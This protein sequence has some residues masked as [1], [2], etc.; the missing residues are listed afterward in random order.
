MV[1]YEMYWD[2]RKFWLYGSM[3]L[4]LSLFL[5]SWIGAVRL[6]GGDLGGLTSGSTSL[7]GVDLRWLR[8]SWWEDGTF[9]LMSVPPG[10]VAFLIG[11]ASTS[12]T[13]ARE[14]DKGTLAALLAQP[15]RRSEIFLGK[16]LAKVL[17]FL[18]VS[19]AIVL[20]MILL[21]TLV[22]GPQLYLVW[23]PVVILD[24]TLILAFYA[25]FAQFLSCFFRRSRSVFF[26]IVLTWFL[27]F[28]LME[29]AAFQHLTL[30]PY[31]YFVPINSA[32]LALAGTRAY[33][34]NPTG[35]VPVSPVPGSSA[36]GAAPAGTL[37][38]L[39]FNPL[40]FG[41]DSTFQFAVMA[42]AGLVLG[43]VLFL[44]LGWYAFRRI[45]IGG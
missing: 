28:G 5:V 26:I 18:G 17:V 33:F 40:S 19:A 37:P 30:L 12:G 35:I 29:S 22:F 11:E 13:V 43:T 23:A 14:R 15:L 6:L 27:L 41:T 24:L 42:T 1:R 31:A 9:L 45:E 4:L 16:F 3:G 34:A 36:F 2:S 7:N 10:F 25:A 20:G 38:F 8:A 21:S 39:S 32:T 44:V